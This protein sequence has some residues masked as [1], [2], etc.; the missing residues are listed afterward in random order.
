MMVK[1]RLAMFGFIVEDMARSLAFY[2][3]LG[4]E[5]PEGSDERE[6][7]V[8]PIGGDLQMFWSTVFAA[9]NDP[10]WTPPSGGYRM[11]IEF[12]GEGNDAVDALYQS[13]TADG[14]PGR[15]P[16]FVTD[17]GAYMAMVED[18]D[19]NTVLITAG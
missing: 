13:L 10:K 1:P 17:F 12:F 11:L 18:P 14:H 2:R 5:F 16:P 8:I 4:I 7:F 9:K 6:G 3:K 15:K 19:G